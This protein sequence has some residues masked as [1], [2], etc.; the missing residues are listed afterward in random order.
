[1]LK[2]DTPVIVSSIVGFIV[3]L[4]F[5]FKQPTLNRL[6]SVFQNWGIIVSAFA[7]GLASINLGRVHVVKVY[8]RQK[9]WFT[10]IVLLATLVGVSVL[11]IASTP[12]SKVYMFYFNNVYNA[13]HSGVSGLLAF[14]VA[15]STFR[16]FRA[17]NIEATLMLV[18][19]FIVMLG[20]APVGEIIYKPLPAA[21]K[22]V[23]D[24]LNMSAQRGIV[25][26]A[27]IG[28]I[29]ASLRVLIGIDR[30]GLTGVRE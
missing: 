27:G 25:I 16:A 17:R 23:T 28:A 21:G 18:S 22:W 8:R 24:V 10:S 14:Y 2:R 1:M 9:D 13:C 19:A 15:S 3:M 5:F 6:S 11:G 4:D 20:L 30:S 12:S 26:T 7:L 29:A